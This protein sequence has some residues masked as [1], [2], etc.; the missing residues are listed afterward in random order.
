MAFRRVTCRLVSL[1]YFFNHAQQPQAMFG[2][3][4]GLIPKEGIE[5]CGNQL[6]DN[7][8]VGSVVTFSAAAEGLRYFLL[9]IR[10]P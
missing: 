4:E 5:V 8:E 1:I 10:N 2:D 3:V 6:S 7:A 9:L